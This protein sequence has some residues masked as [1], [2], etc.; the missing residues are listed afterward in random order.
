MPFITHRIENPESEARPVPRATR[1]AA[2]VGDF[3]L[4][5]VVIAADPDVDQVAGTEPCVQDRIRHELRNDELRVRLDLARQ[6]GERTHTE[7]CLPNGALVGRKSELVTVRRHVAPEI[8]SWSI[9]TRPPAGRTPSG[10]CWA[11]KAEVKRSP[12]RFQ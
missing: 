7:A 10:L 12:S 6:L 11:R 2:A 4:Q 5:A 9:P 1:E 3:D 8:P